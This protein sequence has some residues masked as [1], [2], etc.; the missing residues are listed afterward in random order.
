MTRFKAQSK[1]KLKMTNIRI[2]VV[3]FSICVLALFCHLCFG[4]CNFSFAQQG[5][6]EY[7]LDVSSNTTPLPR[8][9]RPNIDLSGRGLNSKISWPQQLAAKEVLDIWQ[10]DIG[11]N[12]L[13]RIQYNLWE[14]HQLSKAR[15]AQNKLLGNYEN[16][17]KNISDAGGIVIL[18]IFGTPAGLGR[19]L[20]T[21]S[22]PWDLKAFKELIKSAIRI[23]SC[24]KKY[25][26]WYEVWSAPDSDYFF[27]G[28]KQ[29]YLN[30][31]QAVA[32]SINELEAETKIHIPIGGPSVSQWF[33]NVEGNNIATPE[34]SLIYELI[35][36][37][38]AYHL[39]LDFISWH[40]YSSDPQTEKEATIYNK[41]PLALIRDWLSYFNLDKNIPLIVDEWNFDRDA[42]MLPERQERSYVGASYIPARLKN[43]YEAGI[44][45]QLYFCLE[46]FQ[47]NPEGVVRN[48]GIF[49]FD[50]EAAE[51]KGS[52]KAVYNIFRMLNNFK[53]ELFL[54]S[55]KLNDEFVG[56]IA[57]KA[58]D[59]VAMLI[60]NYIDPDIAIGYLTKNIAVLNNT[61]R[62]VIL[63]LINSD[64][65]NRIIQ[66]KLEIASLH[67][68][69]KVKAVL[70]KAQEL[71][72][73]AQKLSLQARNIKIN[74]KN[75]K[76]DYL[77]QRYSTDASCSLNCAFVP[78]EEKVVSA[79]DIYQENLSLNPYSVQL[80]ILKKKPK[81]TEKIPE[82]AP[83]QQ[84][85]EAQPAVQ[86]PEEKPL[87]EKPEEQPPVQP[88]LQEKPETEKAD[89]SKPVPEQPV[90][91]DVK[92]PS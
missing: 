84:P 42:N 45:Y 30:L 44:D 9:F 89:E 59:S 81:E 32:E 79:S 50:S 78:V 61:D 35:K 64:R 40:G 15:D 6:L 5:D 49:S 19:V 26:I 24:Q 10:K 12:N 72:E 11:F 60:Y 73:R 46:D 65:F 38:S 56:T 29:E 70:R 16:I 63:S 28:R 1:S 62:K 77:Y 18:D 7:N 74:I 92:N 27:L 48:V 68:S 13:Y 54:S 2:F 47:N 37:C 87:L 71:N 21:K 91:Q 69:S 80:I 57:T 20:D 67:A 83:Q 51:Y 58:D 33:S 31:Y 88:R 23:L 17:I 25:N 43:M 82:A 22:P 36:F 34:K 75:L 4:I 52:P 41:I 85:V 90:N 86:P 55:L 66:H 8:I 3:P 14:I 53:K 76:E 39:P